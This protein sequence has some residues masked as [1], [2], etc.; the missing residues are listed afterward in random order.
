MRFSREIRFNAQAANPV[1]GE[2]ADSPPV[3]Q[4]GLYNGEEHII[5]PC[6]A[7]VGDGVYYGLHADFPEFIPASELAFSLPTWPGRPVIPDHPPDGTANTP[8]RLDEFQYGQIFYPSFSDNRLR[9]ELWLSPA[10]AA[11][12]G[13]L[14]V[15]EELEAGNMVEISI[16]A[17]IELE[18]LSGTTTSGEA[19]GG[20]WRNISGDHIA[21]GLSGGRGACNLDM[22]CGALRFMSE[23]EMLEVEAQNMANENQNPSARYVRRIA[24]AAGTAGGGSGNQNQ[25]SAPVSAPAPSVSSN[26][27]PVSFL[28]SLATRMGGL[29]NAA[30][31]LV[32]DVGQSDAEIRHAL[33]DAVYHVEPGFGWIEEVFQESMT[34]I[35]SCFPW[36]PE[37]KWYRRTFT[38]T[39][40]GVTISDMR[41]EV[42][43]SGGWE[44]V[45]PADQPTIVTVAASAGDTACGC[46]NQNS[47][48]NNQNQPVQ[49]SEGEDDMKRDEILRRLAAMSDADLEKLVTAP[50]SAAAPGTTTTTTTETPAA[51]AT[52]PA[53]TPPTAP[54]IPAQ[55][56]G[57]APSVP[58]TTPAT[59]PTSPASPSGDPAMLSAAANAILGASGIDVRALNALL[60][61]V[62]S[63]QAQQREM[64][65]TAL[66]SRIPTLTREILA[67][68]SIEQI[69][70]LAQAAGIQGGTSAALGLPV[71]Y[72][73]MGLPVQPAT[74]NSG[75]KYEAPDPFNLKGKAQAAN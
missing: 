48:T 64:L 8:D 72:S 60:A 33:T 70:M 40:E 71:D 11:N 53:T 27:P 24:G 68:Q 74:L 6:V 67:P 14:W 58:A 4:I 2:P 73:G 62:Q 55:A 45:T 28:A 25:V 61:G 35:Y 39:E 57:Q 50:V 17:S 46:H 49:L 38:K 5:V 32:E 18:K 29:W 21:V 31:G 10:R 3:I 16:G 1:S 52:N 26:E 9:F 59:V 43:N 41:E 23:S 20:V 47:S 30:R 19:Y 65:V 22:G 44:V 63:Q 54:A 37:E 42:I 13:T 66:S 12:A 75:K 15:I 69:E 36:S 51:P 7:L 56:P 34:F